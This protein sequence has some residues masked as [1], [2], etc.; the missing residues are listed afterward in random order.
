MRRRGLHLPI[1][2]ASPALPAISRFAGMNR[3][4]PNPH[5]GR[6]RVPAD[7]KCYKSRT[8][9]TGEQADGWQRAFCADLCGEHPFAQFISVAGRRC[10]EGAAAP[11][12]W[13]VTE[14][15]SRKD[16]TRSG[17][18]GIAGSGAPPACSVPHVFSAASQGAS[19]G[20]VQRRQAAPGAGDAAAVGGP[21]ELS[22]WRG[23]HW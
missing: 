16:A 15:R 21:G 9:C 22:L 1:P 2:Q 17:M 5:K 11:V 8:L 12:R 20:R 19:V 4:N 10:C 14:R 3:G 6:G 13:Q 7:Q 23:G 18:P